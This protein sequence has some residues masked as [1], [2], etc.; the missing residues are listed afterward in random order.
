MV[1]VQGPRLRRRA[2][3]LPT[4]PH[5]TD[6]RPLVR[7][8]SHRTTRITR[9]TILPRYPHDTPTQHRSIGWFIAII[10]VMATAT[11]I[12]ALSSASWTL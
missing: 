7:G 1:Q 11:A 12:A 6:L 3:A 9:S 2:E 5:R 10:I 4:L 8:N